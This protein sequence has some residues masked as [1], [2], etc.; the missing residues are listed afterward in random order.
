MERLRRRRA[1]GGDRDS[2]SRQ[3]NGIWTSA[4]YPSGIDTTELPKLQLSDSLL[5]LTGLVTG[6]ST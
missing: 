5:A 6:N 3:R 1:Q 2:E 4:F